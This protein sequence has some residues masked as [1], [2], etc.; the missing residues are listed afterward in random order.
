M[1]EEIPYETFINILAPLL[2]MGDFGKLCLQSRYLNEIFR[3]NLVWKNFYLRSLH[4]KLKITSDSIHT[5]AYKDMYRITSN[6]DEPC[7]LSSEIPGWQN[8]GGMIDDLTATLS[9]CP[10][11]S[12]ADFTGLRECGVTAYKG[13]S[14]YYDFY[15]WAKQDKIWLKQQH[16]KILEYNISQGR[17]GILCTNLSHYIQDT[18]EAPV[19]CRN[20]KSYRKAVLSK[21][22]TASKNNATNRKVKRDLE[23]LL[24][25]KQ[26][27]EEKISMA[28][29]KTEA[30]D[31]KLSDLT[32]AMACKTI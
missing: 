7:Q 12:P 20:L 29:E 23:N 2:S 3:S 6:P 32:T 17:G 18:L 30:A 19:S 5:S 11:V 16:A 26:I 10:C 9:R 27:L 24:K 25:E 14:R 22:L 15:A 28:T 31:R 8:R 21:L 4:D 13:P 1:L